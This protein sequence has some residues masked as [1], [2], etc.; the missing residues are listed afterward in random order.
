MNYGLP[1]PPNRALAW[2]LVA[3]I[4]FSASLWFCLG[5][6]QEGIAF[7]KGLPSLDRQAKVIMA[8][9]QCVQQ[10]ELLKG[11]YL[12]YQTRTNALVWEEAEIQ[13]QDITFTELIQRIEG[14][15]TGDRIFLLDSFQ[16]DV[17]DADERTNGQAAG[18]PVSTVADT[19]R[20][21]LFQIKGYFICP[22]QKDQ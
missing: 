7:K 19:D 22:C 10:Y 6:W 5:E 20:H 16:I 15:Y 17:G 11:Q 12:A 8:T 13:W 9:R 21:I 18:R 2:Q 4:A 14:L 3:T 1:I